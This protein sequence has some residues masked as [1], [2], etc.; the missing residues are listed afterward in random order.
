MK[1]SVLTLL[2]AT[3]PI[4]AM[5]QTALDAYQLSQNDL[6]GTARYMS[7][8]GAFTA[9][10]GDLSTLN[11]N[12]AGIGIYRSS[13]IGGTLNFDFQNTKSTGIG[14]SES[15][16]QT[17]VSCNNFGYVGSVYTGS[18][19][20]PFFT[21]GATYS[22]VA[23]FDRVY[24]GGFSSI[25]G[26]LSNYIADVTTAGKWSPADLNGY[27]M[28]Q[29]NPFQQSAAPWMSILGFNS[30]MINPVGDSSYYNGLWDASK[31]SGQAHFDVRE[32][33][34]VDE[35]SIDFG[36]NISDV[37]YWGVGFGISDLQYTSS[38]YYE[39]DLQNARIPDADATGVE[40]GN[41]GFGLDSWKRVT[42]SG[43]NFKAGVIVRP[44][45]ELRLGFAVH[46]P[47]Y[48]N[49][50]QEGWAQ[51]DY[52]YSSGYSDTYQTD[53]GYNDY[54]EWKL[55][56][57]W[58]M[59]FGVA[60]VIGKQAIISAD[61][62]YRPYQSMNIKDRGGNEYTYMND[63]VSTYYQASNIFRI[64]AEYRITPNWSLRAGYSFQSS[65]VKSSAND[66]T[67]PVDTFG[68]DETETTPSYA[69]DN[70]TYYVSGGVGY[71]YQNF[72]ID[73]AYVYKHRESTFHAYTP[74][75]YNGTYTNAPSATI[76][77]GNSQLVLSLGFKF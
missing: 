45:N 76:T 16:S 32:T 57:P 11:Q 56:S 34:Y 54:F 18:E 67:T 55:R 9:L 7:M 63:D 44:I 10:G 75:T 38:T 61:Y 65:P 20:M 37:V 73:A 53:D 1:K 29:Y 33:G 23:S 4:C 58:R 25:N 24:K 42:G 13:E 47:T 26:S 50:S 41:G 48:Y 46:T 62:E 22:R 40:T 49:L 21:W 28:D 30:Y 51:V 71:R 36:G 27:N 72:Y 68:P 60:G 74:C 19:T 17:K 52:G 5:A 2:A 64:G 69:F 31:T 77:D 12:P 66:N 70:T 14:M 35:Y 6:R 8:G 15:S 43:F 39:E 59:M 3:A